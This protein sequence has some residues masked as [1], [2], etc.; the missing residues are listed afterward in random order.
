MQV[1]IIIN[2]KVKIGIFF[3]SSEDVSRVISKLRIEGILPQE[4][5]IKDIKIL[6]CN[7]NFIGLNDTI[8]KLAMLGTEI[9]KLILE[10]P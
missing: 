6:D 2:D 1:N 9:P 5:N 3:K 8:E 10:I 7:R 4:L